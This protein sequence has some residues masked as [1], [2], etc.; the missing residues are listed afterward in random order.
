MAV[1]KVGYY[2]LDPD[3]VD[4][5]KAQ[6]S[7]SSLI[8][9]DTNIQ[10]DISDI[11]AGARLFGENGSINTIDKTRDKFDENMFDSHLTADID[12]AANASGNVDQNSENQ[13]INEKL[14]I[15]STAIQNEKSAREAEDL[16]QDNRISG[17]STDIESVQNTKQGM[18]EDLF[19]AKYRNPALM[20]GATES[21]NGKKGIVPAPSSG[22]Q[23]SFLH[24][25]AMWRPIRAKSTTYDK[26]GK[27][28]TTYIKD[29]SYELSTHILTFV[30]GDNTVTTIDLSSA[31]G[32]A[33]IILTDSY[34]KMSDVLPGVYSSMTDFDANL[35]DVSKLNT[36]IEMFSECRE[37]NNIDL[38]PWKLKSGYDKMAGMFSNNRKLTSV[39]GMG[40]I[41]VLRNPK[42]LFENCWEL[43]NADLK[44]GLRLSG[45]AM[46]V[47]NNCKK[48]TSLPYIDTSGVTNFNATWYGC[49]SLPSIFPW[50]IDLENFPS[51]TSENPVQDGVYSHGFYGMFTK[52]SVTKVTFKNASDW[53]KERLTASELRRD[54][55]NI[56]IEYV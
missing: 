51:M 14:S 54:G 32:P 13:R 22:Y 31:F 46:S 34:Y 50:T 53:I 11:E 7:T 35:Y 24:G 10:K 3:L 17:I 47:F 49:E 4:F 39:L 36:M 25:D 19:M 23:N 29:V 18:E 40:N 56:Q 20:K 16:N 44:E 26:N 30:H 37:L 6:L 12:K 28:V 55:V 21:T 52:S 43:T 1:K 45:D 41:T 5:L 33:K 38:S 8:Y 2:D 27:D 42:R 9:N 15:L 48:L